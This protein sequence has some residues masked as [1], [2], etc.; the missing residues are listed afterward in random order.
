MKYLLSILC[1]FGFIFCETDLGMWEIKYYVDTF[2]DPTNTPYITNKGYEYGHFENSATS[3]SQLKVDFIIA[4]E[5]EIAIKLYEYAGIHPVKSGNY[6]IYFKHNGESSALT[7]TI[8]SDRLNLYRPIM[9]QK[10]T[11]YTKL[12]NAF[13]QILTKN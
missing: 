7:G 9:L 5:S 10:H 11:G 1:L 6:T 4:S 2:G 3:Y 8:S 13:N 12:L